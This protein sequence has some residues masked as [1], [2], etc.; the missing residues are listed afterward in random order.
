MSHCGVVGVGLD[1]LGEVGDVLAVGVGHRQGVVDGP[2]DH[3]AGD[4]ELA[5]GEAE[6]AVGVGLE[7]VG[8]RAAP[9]GLAGVVEA[10]LAGGALSVAAAAAL[11]AVAVPLPS[12]SISRTC[13]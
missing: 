6:A 2:D 7:A 12:S 3:H 8:E 5:L 11:V 4:G 10:A 9:L 1:R 13:P